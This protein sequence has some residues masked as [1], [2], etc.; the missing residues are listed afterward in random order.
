MQQVYNILNLLTEHASS[1][2]PGVQEPERLAAIGPHPLCAQKEN[3]DVVTFLYT[4]VSY[5]DKKSCGT[6]MVEREQQLVCV[7]RSTKNIFFSFSFFTAKNKNTTTTHRRRL[8]LL[9]SSFGTSRVVF[10]F[11]FVLSVS[12]TVSHL[13]K[14]R[15]L[16]S[17]LH[18]FF[19]PRS[20]GIVIFS[21][22]RRLLQFTA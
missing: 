9:P 11:T 4:C 19:P 12:R 15:P 21:C 2:L 10:P 1:A 7:R 18:L 14:T 17:Q 8:L 3:V 22:S 16:H 5:F 20:F 6:M 13:Q